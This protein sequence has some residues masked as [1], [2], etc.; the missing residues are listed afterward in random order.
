MLGPMP[1]TRRAMG[2]GPRARWWLGGLVLLLAAALGLGAY[3]VRGERWS[4]ALERTPMELV[5]YTERRLEG[6]PKLQSVFGPMLEAVRRSQEREP[7]GQPAHVGQGPA[8]VH[9]GR[10]RVRRCWASESGYQRERVG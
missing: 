8:A 10:A 1:K 2:L 3:L 7:P 5:R 6:H 9:D 4:S